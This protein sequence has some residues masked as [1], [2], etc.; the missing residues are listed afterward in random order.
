MVLIKNTRILTERGLRKMGVRNSMR[1]EI[2][3]ELIFVRLLIS[4]LLN[5]VNEDSGYEVKH[6]CV[7]SVKNHELAL[8]NN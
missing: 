1:S 3:S 4:S 5:K 2:F 6:Y 8:I 7:K